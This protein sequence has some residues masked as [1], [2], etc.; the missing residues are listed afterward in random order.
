MRSEKERRSSPGIDLDSEWFRPR[1][2]MNR[3]LQDRAAMR[4]GNWTGITWFH[5]SDAACSES[6]AP[7]RSTDEHLG[8]PNAPS[9]AS[10]GDLLESVRRNDAG[11]RSHR[12]DLGQPFGSLRSGNSLFRK[13]SMAACFRG[14]PRVR[15]SKAF[16][17]ILA[18]V[19]LGTGQAFAADPY[20]INVILPLTGGG[21]FCRTGRIRRPHGVTR[22]R[23]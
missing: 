1:T 8:N 13:M 11:R 12:R 4:A 16:A 6:R 19:V 10:A 15:L 14:Q 23:Q 7:C 3:Y 22:L 9:R 21:T 17:S 5:S 20:E 18:C 2:T